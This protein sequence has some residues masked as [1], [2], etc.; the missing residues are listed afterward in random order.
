MVAACLDAWRLTGEERWS[1][2]MRRAFRWFLGQNHLHVSLY[3][4]ATGGCCDGL[5]AERSNQ[6]QGAESTLSFLL[7]HTE[8]GMFDSEAR[9]QGR[10]PE[11]GTNER[12]AVRRSTS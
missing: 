11:S 6:N 12:P 10:A 1:Q 3:D 5:H 9:L 7:A 2:E 4:P 8:M